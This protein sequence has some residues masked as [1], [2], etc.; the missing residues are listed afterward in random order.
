M[1][2]PASWRVPPSIPENGT[3]KKHSKLT[4]LQHFEVDIGNFQRCK[5]SFFPIFS[6]F[7][8]R[9]FPFYGTLGFLPMFF[10]RSPKT[11]LKNTQ[12]SPLY[13]IF[14][15]T[16]LEIFKNESFRFP[17]FL[18][19]L[20]KKISILKHIGFFDMFLCQSPKIVFKNTQN[21]H[22]SLQHFEVDIPGN[23]L[24][25]KFSF[26]SIFSKNFFPTYVWVPQ[27]ASQIT[28]TF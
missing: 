25:W 3:Q 12:N 24:K 5:F 2:Q 17:N 23:F 27:I 10:C 9:K 16:F 26:F 4:F 18:K 7:C 14:K 19:I 13:S 11:A 15:L 20:G 28:E 6:K 8:S 1:A 21:H 22:L